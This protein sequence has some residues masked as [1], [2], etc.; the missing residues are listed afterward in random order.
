MA[1]RYTQPQGGPFEVEWG[2]PLTEGL[3]FASEAGQ[4]I[5]AAGRLQQSPLGAGVTLGVGPYGKQWNSTGS[6][7]FAANSF[8]TPG[9]GAFVGLLGASQATWDITVYIAS[10]G[11]VQVLFDQWL[12]NQRWLLQQNGNGMVWVVAQNGAGTRNRTDPIGTVFP[13]AGWYRITGSW[14]GLQNSFL[15]INGVYRPTSPSG[16]PAIIDTI[17]SGDTLNLGGQVNGAFSGGR[18][19]NRGLSI[20]EAFSINANPNQVYAPPVSIAFKAAGGGGAS[21]S[22]ASAQGQSVSATATLTVT[23]TVA[24]AQGQSAAATTTRSISASA[25]SAQGQTASALLA[26]SIY[27]G[28]VTAQGQSASATTTAA[29]T[30]S[31]ASAQGQSALATMAVAGVV[32][33]AT[34]QAQSA[35][36]TATLTVTASVSTA[37]GQSAAAVGAVTNVASVNSG[38]A[39]SAAATATLT[40]TASVSTAQGQSARAS[41]FPPKF[42]EPLIVTSIA[43]PWTAP[44]LPRNWIAKSAARSWNA[45]SSPRNWIATKD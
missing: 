27:A 9:K 14:L 15:I 28:L 34:S 31:S 37:Q 25:A 42:G 38:Q 33:I 32:T 22:V 20:A 17:T 10:T 16:S 21:A 3:I 2:N 29:I 12:Y 26:G 1:T 8:I 7:F 13:S 5:D 39:Q 36:A 23:A 30:A 35:A 4:T 41:Q 6:Q 43:R 24:S 40:I 44:S 19:W 11:A 18:I 45:S